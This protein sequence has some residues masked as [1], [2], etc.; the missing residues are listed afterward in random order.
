M[1]NLSHHSLSTLFPHQA[2]VRKL[3]ISKKIYTFSVFHYLRFARV[4]P[5]SQMR[6]QKGVNRCEQFFQFRFLRGYDNKVIS[7]ADVVL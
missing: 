3:H 6:L 7:V 5:Q 4:Q 1:F 2:M